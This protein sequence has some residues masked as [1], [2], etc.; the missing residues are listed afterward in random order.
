MFETEIQKFRR[1]FFESLSE[2]G[3]RVYREFKNDYLMKKHPEQ[4]TH[5]IVNCFVIDEWE[6]REMIN[7]FW[8]KLSRREVGLYLKKYFEKEEKKEE[9][10]KKNFSF[11]KKFFK[12][13]EREK[14]CEEQK[15]EI[16]WLKSCRK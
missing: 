5:R 1:E 10:K 13:K 12:K 7:L 14:K 16:S 15:E 11:L 2:E 8:E 3:Y 9:E 6:E 4:V